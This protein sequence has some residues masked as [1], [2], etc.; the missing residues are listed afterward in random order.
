[1][2]ARNEVVNKLTDVTKNPQ[3]AQKILTFFADTRNFQDPA[4]Y[5]VI[6]DAA[7]AYLTKSP[8]VKPNLSPPPP[9]DGGESIQSKKTPDDEFN[10]QMTQKKTYRL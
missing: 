6:Y 2:S 10:L 9:I 8:A 1:M 3:K 7:Q 4:L 5:N